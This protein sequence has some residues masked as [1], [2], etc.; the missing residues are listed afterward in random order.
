MGQISRRR[1]RNRLALATAL[2]VA[3]VAMAW[4]VRPVDAA[5]AAF[6]GRLVRSTGRMQPVVVGQYFLL[7][8]V[9]CQLQFGLRCTPMTLPEGR[10]FVARRP[11][12]DPGNAISR[13]DAKAEIAQ[14]LGSPSAW[15]RAAGAAPGAAFYTARFITR[16]GCENWISLG[17]SLF[18]SLI[19]L[20]ALVDSAV[21]CVVLAPVVA[22]GVSWALSAILP[23][24]AS[25]GWQ[26]PL[27]FLVV[28]AILTAG[29]ARDLVEASAAYDR[30]T[31]WRWKRQQARH[32]EA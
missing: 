23:P 27:L 31:R 13:R 26:A 24:L 15:L 20:F 29:Y 17:L 18:V 19:L 32:W 3:V 11:S 21:A 7:Q 5:L 14:G 1:W 22:V 16:N 30:F 9:S 12:I 6:T 25:S 2:G 28:I 10:G 4:F 8:A